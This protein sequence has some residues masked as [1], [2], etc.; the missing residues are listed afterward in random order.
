MLGGWRIG[1]VLAK[2]IERHGSTICAIYWVLMLEHE[3]L[4]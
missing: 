1:K 4:I 2:A 3:H